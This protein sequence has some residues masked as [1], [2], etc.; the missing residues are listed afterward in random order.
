MLALEPRGGGASLG[1]ELL[2]L[3]SDPFVLRV[4]QQTVV[5]SMQVTFWT[6]LLAVPLAFL[7]SIAQGGLR[8]LV[9][10]VIVGSVWLNIIIRSYAWV[11]MLQDNGV[12]RSIA[13]GWGR[14]W[15]PPLYS[16]VSVVIGMVHILIPTA[17]ILITV[18]AAH[19]D[20]WRGIALQQGATLSF[21][22][23]RLFTA[24]ILPAVW[25]AGF[26]MFALSMGFYITPEL[27]GGGHGR[28]MMFA[29]LINQQVIVIGDWTRA[30]AL[31]LILTATVALI[32]LPIGL[33]AP[34]RRAM[35]ASLY[36]V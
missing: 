26:L 29:L 21:F 16:S 18:G 24:S 13:G 27:L 11:L 34:L 23:L 14:A 2:S 6:V 9:F 8:G 20:K 19:V 4:A 10:V 36:K 7:L 31:A 25:V 28:T 22:F 33:V 3:V 1:H 15:V 32:I 12:L 35:R 30:A 5:I 17:V